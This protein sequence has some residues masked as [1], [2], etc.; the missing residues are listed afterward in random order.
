MEVITKETVFC[1][2]DS[3]L[4]FNHEGN[5]KVDYYGQERNIRPHTEHVAF[6]KSLHTRGY[7]ITLWSGNGALWAANVAKALELDPYIH[8]CLT[9]PFKVIDDKPITEW[10]PGVIYIPDVP[11]IKYYVPVETGEKI[12]L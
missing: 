11:Q 6:L 4:I 8:Q 5:I 3:T 1:D 9:K 12:R 2:V 7:H 10:V